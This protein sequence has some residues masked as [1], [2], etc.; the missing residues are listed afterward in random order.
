MNFT[1][2]S[3]LPHFQIFIN[4]GVYNRIKSL[5]IYSECLEE[6]KRRSGGKVHFYAFTFYFYYW[7]PLLHFQIGAADVYTYI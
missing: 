4:S 7:S 3:S 5:H 2:T 6:W 1:P